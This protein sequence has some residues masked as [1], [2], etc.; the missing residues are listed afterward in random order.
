MLVKQITLGKEKFYRIILKKKLILLF[1]IFLFY[2][3]FTN[4]AR[5][6]MQELLVNDLEATR[7]LSFNF[8]Q[9]IAEK[10]EEG[11]CYIKYS[12]LMKCKYI[13]SKQKILISNG[14]SVAIIKKKYKK[15]YYY[16]LESTPL[17]IILDKNKILHL[18]KNNKPT[19]IDSSVIEFEFVDVKSNK[20]KIIFDKKTLQLKGWETEDAYSNNVSFQISNLKKN[21]QIVDSFFKIPQESDL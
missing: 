5:S 18:I 2:L 6:D 19:K 3:F 4:I 14:K 15:I 13:N 17:F 1:K 20:L 10:E 7:T 9:K 8:K 12:L 21:N 16:P 11:N